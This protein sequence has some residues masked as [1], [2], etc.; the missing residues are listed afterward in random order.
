MMQVY[1]YLTGTVSFAP[2]LQTI[3]FL[4][5]D[6]AELLI[7]QNGSPPLDVQQGGGTT[8]HQSSFTYNFNASPY[9]VQIGYYE[10]TVPPALLKLTVTPEPAT[11]TMAGCGL[12]AFAGYQ[13]RRRRARA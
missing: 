6:G 3:K 9:T 12:V 2:G 7:T 13:I 1:V 8:A 11:L 4:H 5:D 10:N